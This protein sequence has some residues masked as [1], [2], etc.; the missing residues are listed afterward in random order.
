MCAVLLMK[1]RVF[2]VAAFLQLHSQARGLAAYS[3]RRMRALSRFLFPYYERSQKAEKH[4]IFRAQLRDVFAHA[5]RFSSLRRATILNEEMLFRRRTR[6]V[7]SQPSSRV[8]NRS[9]PLTKRSTPIFLVAR[10]AHQLRQFREES[11]RS[12]LY[13]LLSR[14][15]QR[16][17]K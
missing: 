8:F 6:S 11:K 13:F 12:N 4:R 5:H 1:P 16:Q 7:G 2:L 15:I 14:R 10:G 9:F 17:K 3:A